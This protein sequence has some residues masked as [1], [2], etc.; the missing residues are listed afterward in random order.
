MLFEVDPI[1][2]HYMTDR[3]QR[4]DRKI[5]WKQ[6]LLDALEVISK[7]NFKVNYPFNV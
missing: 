5:L 6:R 2:L 1:H 4:F 7:I 3:Q